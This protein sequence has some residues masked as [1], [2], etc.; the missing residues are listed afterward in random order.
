MKAIVG[1]FVPLLLLCVGRSYADCE[2]EKVFSLPIQNV[3]VANKASVR[4]IPVSVGTPPQTLAFLPQWPLKD[5]WIYDAYDGQCSDK[6][7]G[8]GCVTYRGGLFKKVDSSSYVPAGDRENND[9]DIVKKA[10]RGTES[11]TL[12]PNVTL[13]DYKFGIPRT[14]FRSSSQRLNALGMG[15]KSSLLDALVSQGYIDS[16]TFSMYWGRPGAASAAQ[17]DG[18]VVFGGYDQGKIRGKNFTTTLSAVSAACPTGMIVSISDLTL[19]FPNGSR[20]DLASSVSGKMDVCMMPNWPV[21]IDLPWDPYYKSF[22]DLT[23]SKTIGRSYGPNYNGMLY[24]PSDVYGGDLTLTLTSGPTVK[25]LNNQLV[26]PNTFINRTDGHIATSANTSEVLINS[27]SS[28]STQDMPKV[29]GPFLSGSYL[30]VD[31]DNNE[32]TLWEAAAVAA[33][34]PS[35]E[36][37]L[38]PVGP[39]CGR[40]ASSPSSDADSSALED[41]SPESGLSS[42]AIAGTVIGVIVGVAGVAAL[43]VFLWRRKRRAQNSAGKHSESD[44]SDSQQE[45][46]ARFAPDDQGP[47][48]D[49]SQHPAEMGSW[50]PPAQLP[51]TPASPNV[52]EM[53]AIEAPVELDG[54]GVPLRE[55]REVGRLN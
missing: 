5:T 12:K 29:G 31:H 43:V 55:P 33:E 53:Q 41:T 14:D 54:L 2:Q 22:E 16:R 38:V 36:E 19:G 30:H 49:A 35:T 15:V 45:M 47:H 44:A 11:F 26:V 21:A 48:D 8:V 39:S 42:G 24:E 18:H 28:L 9:R 3:E 4:G 37:D 25:I 50:D 27:L 6:T 13:D 23:R 20:S 40:K 10:Q 7:S 32:F 17:R 46:Y 1:S 34:K 51:A 52:Q